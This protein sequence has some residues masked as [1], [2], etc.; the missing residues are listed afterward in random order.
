M[1][2]FRK[3]IGKSINDLGFGGTC[4]ENAQIVEA[5]CD[6]P[7]VCWNKK[8]LYLGLYA[9]DFVEDACFR[10]KIL[11]ESG[12]AEWTVSIGQST[13]PIRARIGATYVPS[14]QQ[15]ILTWSRNKNE[16]N[17]RHE[18]RYA[19]ENIHRIGWD[20]AT[21]APGGTIVPPG[22]QGY[23]GMVYITTDIA[24]KGRKVIFLAIRPANTTR[25]SQIELPI[26]KGP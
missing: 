10:D 2:V 6:L 19:F 14:E 3:R 12:R 17:V 22:F 18:V 23:N 1:I 21:P 15:L 5:A 9:H 4:L 8:D 26:L 11:P 25:F 13:E 16:N 20:K 24:L 7:R